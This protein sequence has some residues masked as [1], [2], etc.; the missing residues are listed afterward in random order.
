MLVRLLFMDIASMD[1]IFGWHGNSI[2]PV[3]FDTIII[4]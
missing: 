3:R 4:L 2:K 1:D